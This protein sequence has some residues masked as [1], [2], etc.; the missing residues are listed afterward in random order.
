MSTAA[1]PSITLKST[2]RKQLLDILAPRRLRVLIITLIILVGATLELVPPLVLKQ[3]VDVH[4]TPANPNG[5]WP[6]AVIYLASVAGVQG[7]GF[8]TNYLTALTSQGALNDLRVRLYRHLQKMPVRYYDQ[9]PLGDIISRC[10]ADVD[11]IDTLFS[12]G[13]A[14]LI[15]DM[16]RLIT[17]SIAM[18][19][20]SPILTLVSA[21]V[22]PLVAW[23]TNS[24]RVRIRSA[25]RQNRIAVGMLNTHLQETFGGVEVIRAFNREPIFIA[26]FRRVLKKALVAYNLTAKYSSLYAPIMQILMAI[27]I[28]LLLWGGAQA[29][30]LSFQISLG[31]LTAFVFLFKHFFDPITALGDEW[32]TVQSALSGAERIFQVLDMP[33]EDIPP[34]TLPEGSALDGGIEIHNLTFGY[35]EGQ[36]VLRKVTFSVAM[37]EHVALVGRTGAG[38]SSILNLLGGLY[39][40][41]EGSILIAGLDPRQIAEMDRRRVIGIVPQAVQL[42]SGTVME[43]LTLSDP[44]ISADAVKHAVQIAGAKELVHSFPNGY[45]TF[46]SNGSGSGVQLSSG[47][48]QILSLARAMV[49]DPAILLFDE[50]TSAIDSASEAAFR[51]ALQAETKRHQRAIL[52]VAHRLSTAREADR[53]IVLENG[54]ILEMGTPDELIQKGGRF[55]AL[56][57]LEAAGWDWHKDQSE[58]L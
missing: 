47:Q 45:D 22:V 53:V 32:Q 58:N 25:E 28:S 39:N 57:E 13:V 12:S 43:N 26:R 23:V 35:T 40:P 24:F 37:G 21:L 36:P 1:I 30:Q 50:A 46:I 11:T 34:S 44:N 56:L 2:T 20:L 18:I 38:K 52:T 29:R 15:T 16:I 3:I 48:R 14:G 6:L 51:E 54:R 19:S 9:N 31:T 27:A 55:A 5:I 17:V 41:W 42:F 10:T 33:T 8:L 49:C 7:L 4:L